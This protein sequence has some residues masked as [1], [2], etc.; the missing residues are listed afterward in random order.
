MQKQYIVRRFNPKDLDSVIKLNWVFLPENYPSFFF[1][2]N[3][4]HWPEA[5]FVA[6]SEG[7]IV[8]YVMCRVEEKYYRFSPVKLGHVLSIA[9]DKKHRR[10]GVATALM[11][12]AEEGLVG[13]YGVDVIYLEVRVSNDP[14]ISLYKKLD[15]RVLG[16]MPGYYSDGEDG[17]LM[18]KSTS[19]RADDRLIQA[20]LGY[21]VRK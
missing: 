21:R 18:V 7:K 13:S 1:L 12:R 19:E 20:V 4:T 3:Y 8:G 11:K 10:R 2:E 17:Y 6:E 9:V 15:Y 14:A 5:F 16:V